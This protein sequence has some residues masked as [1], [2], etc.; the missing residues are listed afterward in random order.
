[1]GKKTIRLTEEDLSSIVEGTVKRIVKEADRQ[2][3]GGRNR[4]PKKR[5]RKLR[6]AGR[7]QKR[8]KRNQTRSQKQR[9][10]RRK[11]ATGQGTIG[12]T[13]RSIQNA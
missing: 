12:N 8:T 10:Q 4:K 2:K 3:K 9:N 7:L 6:Q 1:M 11:T 5:P 13:T